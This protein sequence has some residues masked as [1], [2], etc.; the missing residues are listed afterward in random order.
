MLNLDYFRGQF[1][2]VYPILLDAAAP[3]PD[4]T[5]ESHSQTHAGFAQHTLTSNTIITTID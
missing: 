1:S 4:R 2:I 3:L 5:S